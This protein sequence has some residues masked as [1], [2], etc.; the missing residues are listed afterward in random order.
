MKTFVMLHR[1][2]ML[3]TLVILILSC[4]K[5]SETVSEEKVV[6]TRIDSVHLTYVLPSPMMK[7]NVTIE[8][9]L[10]NRRSH[11]HFQDREISAENLSQILW[12]S[13]GITMPRNDYPFL[14]GGLRTAPS[15]GALYPLEIYVLVGKVKGIDSGVYKYIPVGHR[16]IRTIEKDLRRELGT[17]SLDQEMIIAAPVVL[18]YSAIFS[19]STEK[20]GARG[21]ERYVCMDLGHSAENV[22]LQ[23]EALH[24]GTCAIGAFDDDLVKKTL[25]L[26]ADEEPLYIMPIGFYY[27]VK[28]F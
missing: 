19:R 24:L 4:T 5:K 1:A 9:A 27:N 3:I 12:A 26:P 10:S 2:V 25:Q 15:A 16:I 21:R 18:F 8:E 6:L 23:V 17:A 28:E 14:R 13:Y 7:G 22:Y 11:R 20:Y